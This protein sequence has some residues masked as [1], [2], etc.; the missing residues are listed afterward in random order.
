M[1]QLVSN[2]IDGLLWICIKKNYTYYQKAK[3]FHMLSIVAKKLADQYDA[4]SSK[5]KTDT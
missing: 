5:T 4:V 1:K 2:C 3:I